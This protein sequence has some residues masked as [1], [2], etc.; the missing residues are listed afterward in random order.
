MYKTHNYKLL[1]L[2]RPLTPFDQD[3]LAVAAFRRSRRAL[4]RAHQ[5]SKANANNPCYKRPALP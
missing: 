3:R 1:D 4:R 2:S 5:I